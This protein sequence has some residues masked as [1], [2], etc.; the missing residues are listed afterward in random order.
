LNLE[1]PLAFKD[2]HRLIFLFFF[3]MR[4]MSYVLV[5]FFL[6]IYECEKDPIKRHMKDIWSKEFF[7]GNKTKSK[8]FGYIH[9]KRWYLKYSII[10]F[11]NFLLIIKKIFLCVCVT[12]HFLFGH[13]TI[14][15]CLYL[16]LWCQERL[17]I[18]HTNKCNEKRYW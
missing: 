13:V 5:K 8:M 1:S 15:E 2:G 16:K 18:L 11:I 3:Q 6:F 10:F 17:C 14:L 9:I 4:I 12:K 7:Y